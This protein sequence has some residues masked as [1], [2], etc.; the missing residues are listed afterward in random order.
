MTTHI[1]SGPLSM[2]G[3]KVE[4]AARE[5]GVAFE[6]TMVPFTKDDA[7]EPKHPEVLR[8]NAVKQQVPV[9]VDDAVA[10]FDSTQIF[11]YL[12]DR[13]PTPAL[14]PEGI[15]DRARARQL[16]QKS[17]EVF[18]PNVIK[19]FGLQNDMQSAPAVAACAACARYYAEMEGLLA[20]REYLAGPYSFVDIAFYMACIFADRKG[21][22]M[23]DATPRLIAW[24]NRVRD[25]PAVHA[26]VDPMMKF[27]AS[28][29]R[30]VPAFLQR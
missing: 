4:I 2:F 15:A 16:E 9:L 5:K 14:W 27:L 12:E 28:E 17:D 19:L 25:R 6:L 29:G 3:A 10:L 20:G 21:A 23:T 26:V 24:R 13:Y 8:V 7:Y 1:Y 30:E 18:F 11:E 22:G